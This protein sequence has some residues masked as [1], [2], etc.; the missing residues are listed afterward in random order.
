M[1]LNNNIK[2]IYFDWGGTF[3]NQFKDITLEADKLLKPFDLKWETVFPEFF[4]LYL[5]RSKGNLKN[6][7]KMSLQLKRII[8]KD[9][10]VKKII[11]LYN[12]AIIIPK[13]H[14]ELVKELKESYKVGIISNGVQEW[15]D[16]LQRANK[17]ENLFDSVI[18][19][20][21]VG[22]RKPDAEIYYVALRSLNVKPEESIFIS[23]ELCDDLIGAKGCGIKTI[24]YLP[25]IQHDRKKKVGLK[26]VNLYKKEQKIAKLFKPDFVIRDL[27]EILVILSTLS[28]S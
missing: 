17:I 21:K 18:V 8:Q 27:K 19:S 25:T 13:E 16:K 5:L 3:V 4:N 10:P 28:I 9:I 1:K 12:S 24:W 6:D 20:S 15:I 22:V 11:D 14:I 26:K 23:D 2:A 7:E